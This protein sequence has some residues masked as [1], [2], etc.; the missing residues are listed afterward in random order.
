MADAS[1]RE[2]LQGQVEELTRRL[3]ART[4]ELEVLHEL[5]QKLGQSLSYAEL[6]RTI[7]S[8]L[9]DA[10][11][12][13]VA[14]ALLVAP[15]VRN[16]YLRPARP[17]APAAR[18]EIENRLLTALYRLG[19]IDVRPEEVATTLLDTDPSG[20]AGRPLE[21]LA[22][23][24]QVPILG[25]GG[26]VGLLLLGSATPGHFNEDHVRLLY[27]VAHQA[28]S[29]VERLNARLESERQRLQAIVDN[30]PDGILLLDASQHITMANPPGRLLLAALAGPAVGGKL[31]HLNGHSFED[32]LARCGDRLPHDLV[33]EGPPRRVFEPACVS[34]EIDPL[35]ERW[36]IVLRDVTDAREAVDR[37]DRFLAMLAHELRNPLSPVMNA[38]CLLGRADLDQR[39]QQQAV[40]IISRQTRHI[41]RLIDDLMDVSRFLHGKITLMPQRL[42]LNQLVRHT[43]ETY[44]SMAEE[45]EQSLDLVCSSEPL[46]IQ[47]DPARLAQVVTNLLAN[48]VKFTPPGGSIRLSTGCEAAEAVIRVRDSGIG[49]TSDKL[50]EIFLPFVQVN[51]SVPRS[52]GGLGIGLSL[53]K[54][55]VSLHGGSVLVC[56]DGP[57]RG[58][59]FTVRLPMPATDAS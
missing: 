4:F 21:A 18:V 27:T 54:A 59:E 38:S 5:S 7:L 56:S 13:E 2:S 28:A 24:F 42:E 11:D 49:L 45:R 35:P 48:A 39:T 34:L 9:G 52:N 16:L 46:W 8:R 15:G 14:A 41:A 19:G 53:V 33:L 57:D 55:L 37:R 32:I 1:T 17:L 6:F 23:F 47:G 29:A 3:R 40:Q 44:R 22:S 36:M 58:C 25:A 50:S 51:E 26:T 12:H 31:T 10:I 30:L 43:V 20:V